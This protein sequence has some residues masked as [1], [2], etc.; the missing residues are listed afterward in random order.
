MTE[1]DRQSAI[2]TVSKMGVNE[3]VAFLETI[4][5]SST[6]Y[7]IVAKDLDG[8][9]L[10]WNEGARR[11]CGYEPSEMIGKANSL[12]LHD[13][14]DVGSGYARRIMGEARDRKMV[15]RTQTR[16]QERQ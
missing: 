13:P 5:E 3:R 4:L 1:V 6:E 14:E 10:A 11:I 9:V 15:G 2:R 8:T 7:S 12:I 16:A